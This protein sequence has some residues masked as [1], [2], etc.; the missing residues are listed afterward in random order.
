MEWGEIE[1]SQ[2]KESYDLSIAK[3]PLTRNYKILIML[4]FN[5]IPYKGLFNKQRRRL[6]ETK[7]QQ[8]QTQKQ[9]S[10]K[11]RS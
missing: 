4:E 2:V 11:Y 9:K 7:K 6:N 3:T 5:Q 10:T 8:R 1:I